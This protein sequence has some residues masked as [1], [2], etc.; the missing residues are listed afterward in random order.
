MTELLA[1]AGDLEA[2]YAALAYGAD[3]V[4]LGLTRF[5]ARA[6]ATNF[7]PEALKT[8]TAFAH[9]KGKRV[10]VAV[11]TVIFDEELDGLID[12][13][14]AV[15]DAK[16]DGVIVQDLG[17][18][19]I[20]RK[21]FPTLRLHGST[22]MAV[23]NREG[24]EALRDMGFK[25]VVLARELTLDEIR[26]ICSVPGIEKEVFVH[27]ALCYSY[28]GLCQFSS[29]Y[30]GRSANRGKC[31]YPCR[32]SFCFEGVN[33]HVF[34]MKDLAQSENVLLLKQAG[35]TALK[36]EGRKKSPLYVAA[37]TDYY[38]SIL[39]GVTDKALL[40]QKLNNIRCI[41]SR[42]T[43]SLYLTNPENR[44]VTDTE[45]VG[46]RGLPLGEV[47][48]LTTLGKDRF[49]RFKTAFA[50]SRYDGVQI[51]LP[52]EE[53]PFGFSA[54][55]LRVNGK[56][57]F[58]A[59]A[60]TTVD[61]LLPPHS[62]FIPEKAAVYL[63]SASAVK[64]A[65][66]YEK[67][68]EA[69]FAPAVPVCV[70]VRVAPDSVT[71]IAE[72][73]TESATGAFS[74]AKS[75]ETANKSIRDSFAKTGGTGLCLD[76]IEIENDGLFVPMAVLNEV[77]R[78]LY[79]AV[80]ERLTERAAA[81]QKALKEKI[82][83]AETASPKAVVTD[84]PKIIVKTDQPAIFTAFEAEDWA[85][86]DEA[87]IELPVG[88]AEPI[89]CPDMRKIRFALPTVIRARDAWRKTMRTLTAQGAKKFEIGNIGG[90]TFLKGLHADIAFDRFIYVANAAAAREALALGASRFTVSYEAPDPQALFAAFSDKANAV[91][92]QDLPL[93]ISETCPY[94]SVAGKCLK[95]GGCR[96]QTISSRY[97]TFVSV[98]KHCR[99]FLLN[100]KP[101]LRKKEAEGAQ[102]RQI[103]F[104]Y[105]NWTPQAAVEMF[106]KIV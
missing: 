97:G 21:Y 2:G 49:V 46:H 88:Y 16:A 40:T 61:V 69:D 105:R 44:R 64:S 85:K 37:V 17:T 90:L 52:N 6:E 91:I 8:F 65:Y 14:C 70:F 77:R 26:D 79:N 29:V 53:R 36:I 86:I 58:S 32:E 24:V 12:T 59:P 102:W 34:S 94:A 22:Q 98:M 9:A 45:I 80:S 3:A 27:G 81:E 54:E 76:K 18:A 56:D 78:A 63:S 38:R 41:F 5:S 82:L 19:R 103:D 33:K 87:V 23:H 100:E 4:Y 51:D 72:G 10:L 35:V 92:Y 67:P 73:C 55:R 104:M 39:N 15:R 31:V 83:S 71:A 1:P 50:L 89:A 62:P 47:A 13:L 99:H 68:R 96:Q 28:S 74:P 11:N 7:T 101:H 48:K 42:P 84:R 95:C 30:T 75:L 66:P 43:T 20:I 60:K 106:R 57:V 93:F 25:R